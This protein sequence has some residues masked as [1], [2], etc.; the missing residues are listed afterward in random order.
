LGQSTPPKTA[1]ESAVVADDADREPKDAPEPDASASPDA[2]AVVAAPAPHAGPGVAVRL[3]FDGLADAAIP[4]ADGT[5][6]G[7]RSAAGAYASRAKADNT[8]RD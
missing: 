6:A 7:G 5:L 3:W 4:A 8:R 1:R 2:G